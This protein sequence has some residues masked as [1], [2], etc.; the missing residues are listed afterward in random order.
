[1]ICSLF[2]LAL[3]SSARC[4]FWVGKP[5]M[6]MVSLLVL[7]LTRDWGTQKAQL[8]LLLGKKSPSL[9]SHLRTERAAALVQRTEKEIWSNANWPLVELRQPCMTGLAWMVGNMCEE[10]ILFTTIH[11]WRNNQI[12][13]SG[14]WTIFTHIKWISNIV[15]IEDHT[16]KY[17]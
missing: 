11:E 8:L 2:L 17:S 16:L 13:L 3:E 4:N 15:T 14:A 6:V 12:L 1:M 7:P 10:Y 5:F 9:A